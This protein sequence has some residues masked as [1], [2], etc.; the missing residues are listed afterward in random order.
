MEEKAQVHAASQGDREAFSYLVGQ[1]QARLISSAFQIV[2]NAEDAKDLSQESLIEAYRRLPELKD[3]SKFRPW[4]FVILRNKCFRHLQRL[5]P[6]VPLDACQEVA[7]PVPVETSITDYLQSMSL[8]DR[9]ILA[10]RYLQEMDY[11]EIAEVLGISINAATVRCARA[12]ERLRKI[13]QNAEE[14]EA[15]RL[16]TGVCSIALTG[17]DPTTF[18]HRV[19][20][21]VNT[22]TQSIAL[23]ST[24]SIAATTLGITGKGILAIGIGWKIAIG[25]MIALGMI[26]LGLGTAP[27][28][29][30]GRPII[31]L[32]SHHNKA[33]KD[34]QPQEYP[35]YAGSTV[36]CDISKYHLTPETE[37]SAKNLLQLSKAV[38]RY[39][40]DHHGILPPLDITSLKA[41]ENL[42]PSVWRQPGSG[43]EYMANMAISGK[44]I[45][46]IK[47]PRTIL[48]YEAPWPSGTRQVAFIDGTGGILDERAW[49]SLKIE[50]GIKE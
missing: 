3:P 22:M 49:E 34:G 50:A 48:F 45:G 19:M 9:E 6:T 40:Q 43:L 15:R 21:E 47:N 30:G 7:A 35:E 16:L 39:A 28:G 4:L 17:I 27:I 38:R 8:G 10:A 14:A 2:G 11:G 23:T 33:A 25:T 1:Y 31:P 18:M 36:R 26:A 32:F 5:R 46:E 13:V 37:Q 44:S 29:P 24:S 12:R 42:P 41:I 20:Q